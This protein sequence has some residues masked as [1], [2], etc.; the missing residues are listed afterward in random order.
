MYSRVIVFV[1]S[2][3][4]RTST[5]KKQTEPIYIAEPPHREGAS[6][7]VSNI[8][9]EDDKV[10]VKF[11]LSPDE[12]TVTTTPA[13]VKDEI[14]LYK[15]FGDSGISPKILRVIQPGMPK[16][17]YT[18]NEFLKAMPGE[19][20]D[21]LDLETLR[22]I[23][24]K[25][26]CFYNV[27]HSFNPNEHF[28][29]NS[30]FTELYEFL[31]TLVGYGYYNIDS[32]L[33]NLC[34]DTDKNHFLLIDLDPQY[35]IPTTPG[36]NDI[37]YVHYMAFQVYISMKMERKLKGWN[38]YFHHLKMTE[39]QYYNMLQFSINFD[40]LSN[41]MMHNIKNSR[42]E[43]TR[44]NELIN[45]LHRVDSSLPN[46]VDVSRIAMRS[47]LAG[48]SAFALY[49]LMGHTKRKRRKRKTNK[50]KK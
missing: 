42:R 2:M 10:I 16:V 31:L 3:L 26:D 5:F 46:K 35:V 38:I 40:E 30:F 43:L 11:K 28:D 14:L 6:K 23:V 37:L 8:Q 22:L 32:K 17:E 9:G 39:Q 4:S 12:N 29:A 44:V 18:L 24:E 48:V 25:K 15:T 13:N 49:K 47:A 45:I 20:T 27:L 7:I 1:Y 19:S 33:S 21:K 36:I 34:Y 50:N 41:M